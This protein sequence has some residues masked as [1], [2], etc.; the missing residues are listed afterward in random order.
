MSFILRPKCDLT[1]TF[2]GCTSE[3]ESLPV[4]CNP[5]TSRSE[6][7]QQKSTPKKPLPKVMN[8]R[9]LSG[10]KRTKDAIDVKQSMAP[11]EIYRPPAGSMF[12]LSFFFPQFI[13]YE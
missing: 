12:T 3:G 10:G 1:F 2:S 8:A 11:Q 13:F 4:S 5:T 9:H 7:P 6:R